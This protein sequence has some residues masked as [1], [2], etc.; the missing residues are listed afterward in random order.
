MTSPAKQAKSVLPQLSCKR[1]HRWIK[2][3]ALA[4]HAL[5]AKTSLSASVRTQAGRLSRP[6]VTPPDQP[7][8]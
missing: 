3:T 4:F 5:P 6:A 1:I 8:S 7:G 2:P